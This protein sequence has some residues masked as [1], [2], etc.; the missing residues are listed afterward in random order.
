[1]KKFEL[2]KD[3][4]YLDYVLNIFKLCAKDMCVVKKI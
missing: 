4:F 2:L 1:M 3:M